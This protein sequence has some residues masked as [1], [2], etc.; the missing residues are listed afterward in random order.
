MTPEQA[1]QDIQG[2]FEEQRFRMQERLDKQ[3]L[4]LSHGDYRAHTGDSTSSLG[5]SELSLSSNRSSKHLEMAN[6][7]AGTLVQQGAVSFKNDPQGLEA[8]EEAIANA[9]SAEKSRRRAILET[10]DQ[11]QLNT[12][13]VVAEEVDEWGNSDQQDTD[14]YEDVHETAIVVPHPSSPSSTAPRPSSRI[15]STSA[16]YI[17]PQKRRDHAAATI[18]PHPGDQR[19][20]I[21]PDVRGDRK[22]RTLNDQDNQ[23]APLPSIVEAGRPDITTADTRHEGESRATPTGPD[24]YPQQTTY[25]FKNKGAAPQ[26]GE[27]AAQPTPQMQQSPVVH[28]HGEQ[29]ETHRRGHRVEFADHVP[30][31]ISISMMQDYG[32]NYQQ[33]FPDPQMGFLGEGNMSGS[34]S[35]VHDGHISVVR[36]LAGENTPEGMFLDRKSREI[37]SL[38]KT[39]LSRKVP[40]I[41]CPDGKVRAPKVPSPVYHHWCGDEDS[42]LFMQVLAG[43]LNYF[44]GNWI[45]SDSHDDLRVNLLQQSIT[46]RALIWYNDNVLKDRIRGVTRWKYADVVVAMY[47]HFVHPRLIEDR[48]KSFRTIEY[49]FTRTEGIYDFYQK[50]YNACDEMVHPISESEFCRRLFDGLPAEIRQYLSDRNVDPNYCRPMG[51]VTAASQWE[52]AARI[53]WQSEARAAQV[54][55]E[56]NGTGGLVTKDGV[57]AGNRGSKSEGE[58]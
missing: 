23:Y 12:E 17:P 48:E 30:E 41:R 9:I 10:Q 15:Q 35:M 39:E 24:G 54:N 29:G 27:V 20:D 53:Y 58:E 50:L 47:E 2:N 8:F 18:T 4:Q 19:I 32:M 16:T 7:I 6:R 46:G 36:R 57:Q 14:E 28:D 26:Q 56:S 38:I 25:Q 13:G 42:N 51:I 33:R 55:K 31:P 5:L 11:P 45:T 3:A 40:G 43:Q 21:I 22:H 34:I 49:Q 44:A 37:R 52:K 1:I